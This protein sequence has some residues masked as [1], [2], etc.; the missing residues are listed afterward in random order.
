MAADAHPDIVGQ[1]VQMSRAIGAPEQDC[2][3]LGEGNTSARVDGKSFLVKASGASLCNAGPESFVQVSFSRV[4]QILADRVTDDAAVTA[5]LN[6]ARTDPAA[7]RR[8][9]VETTFHGILL[10]LPGVNFVG[11]CHPTAVN[12]LLCSN[13]APDIFRGRL[14]PDEIVC[15]GPEPVWVPYV[16]PGV[17]LAL[18]IQEG[19]EAYRG[20]WGTPPRIILMQ[21]HGLIA[22][23]K[24]PGEVESATAMYVKT[25]RILLGTYAL[26]G[27]NFLS[28]ENVNRIY[29]RPDEKSREKQIGVA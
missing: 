5:R 20:R 1:L 2:A 22:V 6:D 3:I 28:P 12:A 9:S 11:H 17:P 21:N 27:P 26:G 10:S 25:A 4:A 13:A 16:D 7:T 19:V 24:S 15:C 23:G 14:F 29:T 18:A 8:P